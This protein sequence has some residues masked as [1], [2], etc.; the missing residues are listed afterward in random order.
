MGKTFV[1]IPPKK[2]LKRMSVRTPS[3]KRPSHPCND[4]DRVHPTMTLVDLHSMHERD[5]HPILHNM[6]AMRDQRAMRYTKCSHCGRPM[7]HHVG[8]VN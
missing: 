4:K 6:H 5:L 1:P 2:G 3:Y 7:K 8:P